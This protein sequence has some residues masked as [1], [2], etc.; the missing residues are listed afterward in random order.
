MMMIVLEGT[1]MEHSND[2]RSLLALPGARSSTTAVGV[3]GKLVHA[4]GT[5]SVRPV[6]VA[7]EARETRAQILTES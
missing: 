3:D 2:D 1:S 4:V 7:G 5:R 6:I